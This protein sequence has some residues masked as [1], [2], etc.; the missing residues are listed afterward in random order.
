MDIGGDNMSS[1]N[2][3]L[4]IYTDGGC[5]N[6]SGE[7]HG[8]GSYAFLQ[9]VDLSNE[10]VEIYTKFVSD[11]TN[12]RTEMLA[13]LSSIEYFG[14][15]DSVL[16]IFTDS[17]YVVK[18][19]TNPSYLDKWIQNGWKTSTKKPVLNKDLWERF[20]SIP[21]DKKFCL[22][23]IKGHKKDSNPIHSFWNDICDQ[24]CTYTMNE[25]ASTDGLCKLRYYLKEKRIEFVEEIGNN[26]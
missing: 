4:I 25:L 3:V 26:E 12:N 13:I 16:E 24:A 23:L 6:E 8:I 11:T 7:M 2:K 21:W 1:V 14:N 20:L 15:E 10:Y 19:Y 22:N 9:P 18:G 17:G 5:H